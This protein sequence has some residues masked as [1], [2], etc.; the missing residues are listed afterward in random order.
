[1]MKLVLLLVLSGC[2]SSF[3]YFP[4][5]NP[6]DPEPQDESKPMAVFHVPPTVANVHLGKAVNEFVGPEANGNYMPSCVDVKE[7]GRPQNTSGSTVDVELSFIQNTKELFDKTSRNFTTAIALKGWGSLTAGHSAGTTNSIER[8]V[9][10]N[11][12]YALLRVVKTY[13]PSNVKK[14]V[15]LENA[16]DLFPK[17]ESLLERCGTGYI[18]SVTMGAQA[19][20]LIECESTNASEK[21]KVDEVIKAS[22][23]YSSVSAEAS[24]TKNIE[25]INKSSSGGCRLYASYAGGSGSVALDYEKFSQSLVDYIMAGTPESA[26]PV[27][28][29][30]SSYENV[31]S[32]AFDAE[33][34][35]KVR[36]F[37]TKQGH[38][39]NP[40]VV[41][42][43]SYFDRIGKMKAE[44]SFLGE[45][46]VEV[47]QAIADLK[48][49]AYSKS[50][51]IVACAEDVSKCDEGNEWL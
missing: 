32:V 28:Y 19:F 3:V 9:K 46:S 1:M 44:S 35:G 23:G 40:R 5:P 49:R 22:A 36:R 24:L 29:E 34:L 51:E 30:T 18:N 39:I 17:P 10:A 48:S 8:E 11:S 45:L 42:M 31:Q 50:L 7:F 16:A 21:R 12:S 37:I 4:G 6:V 26:V 47:K 27:R 14:V 2:G 13:V 41:N 15:W 33:F 20:G 43:N 38:Y 25:K